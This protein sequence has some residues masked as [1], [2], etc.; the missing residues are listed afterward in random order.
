MILNFNEGMQ[1]GKGSYYVLLFLVAVDLLLLVRYAMRFPALG[2]MK[3]FVVMLVLLVI[4]VASLALLS[5]RKDSGWMAGSVLFAIIMLNIAYG[6]YRNFLGILPVII[7][8]WSAISFVF[9]T[10]MIGAFWRMPKPIPSSEQRVESELKR[11][12]AALENAE[13]DFE[14]AV[15]KGKKK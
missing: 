3:E 6:L 12:A 1:M 4:A 8:L 9:C 14:K 11:E 15:K 7:A 5:Q 13:K 2:F 10:A